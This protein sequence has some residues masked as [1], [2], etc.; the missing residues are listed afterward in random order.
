MENLSGKKKVVTH[1]RILHQ[2]KTL[3]EKNGLTRTTIDDIAAAAAI[4]RSTFFTHFASLDELYAEISSAETESLLA[5]LKDLK[6]RKFPYDAI[7]KAYLS[8]LIDDTAKYPKTFVELFIKSVLIAEK[9]N[10]RFLEIENALCDM[11]KY[12]SPPTPRAAT[13]KDLYKSLFGLYFGIVF[14]DLI[15]DKKKS[16]TAAMKDALALYIDTLNISTPEQ[17]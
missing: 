17:D 6:E 3:F 13:V 12:A 7:L 5:L 10:K 2:A 14:C 9:P 4:A 1:L 15:A 16:E 8:K 11:L